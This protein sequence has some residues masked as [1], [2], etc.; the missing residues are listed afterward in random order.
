MATGQ[1]KATNASN[2][3]GVLGQHGRIKPITYNEEGIAIHEAGHA[4]FG[5]VLN[6]SDRLGDTYLIVRNPVMN[7][8][9][10]APGEEWAMR[11][12]RKQGA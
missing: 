2:V 12:V 3:I 1:G 11:F 5:H 6:C 8:L 7:P 9:K 4:V 10:V